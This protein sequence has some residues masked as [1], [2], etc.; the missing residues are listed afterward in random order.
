M[1]DQNIFSSKKIYNMNKI[2]LQ[3][4][5]IEGVFVGFVTYLLAGNKLQIAEILLI[6]LSSMIILSAL[7]RFNFISFSESYDRVC[8]AWS[9][10]I[11]R[12]E[13]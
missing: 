8:R 9:A 13:D 6:A 3:R 11:F 12:C 1:N 5:L 4:Y 7:D 10:N 2:D